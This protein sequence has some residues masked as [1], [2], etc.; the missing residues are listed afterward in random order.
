MRFTSIL[1]L[2]VKKSSSRFLHDML[3]LMCFCIAPAF[4]QYVPGVNNNVTLLGRQDKYNGYSN[5]WGYT[6]ARG[7]EYALVG[8]DVGLSVVNITNPGN[9]IEVDFVPGPGPTAW[10]EIKTF[11]HYAYVVSEASSPNQYSGVQVV[12]L[13]TLPDS[14]KSFRSYLWPN[15]TATNARAHSISVDEAGYLYIQG[16]NTT[17]GTG[18]AGNGVRILSLANPNAPA[19]VSVFNARY[20]HDSYTHKNLLFNSNIQNGGRVD[21]V[22][23]TDRANP[24]FVTAITYPNGASHNSGTTAD[25]NYLITTDEDADLTVKIWDIRVLWDNDPN[26]NGNIE[27]VAEIP[28]PAGSIAHNVH[29]RGDYAF[30]AHYTE[31][32]KVFDVSDPR[33]P[34]EVGYYDS[35]RQAGTGF[36]GDWGV[37]PYY[38]SGNFVISDM[39]TGLYVLRLDHAGV[40]EVRGR[41][42]NRET[43]AALAGATVQFVEANRILSTDNNGEYFARTNTGTHTMIVKAFPFKTD[44]VK[45]ELTSGAPVQQDRALAPVLAM[46]ALRG[47]VRDASGKAVRAK[48]SLFASSNATAPFTLTDSSDANGE[49]SFENIFVTSPPLLQYDKL[50]IE[51]A[52]P[53]VAQTEEV[54]TVVKDAP[55]VHNFALSPAQVLLVNDDPNSRYADYYLDALKNLNVTAYPWSRVQRGAV[56]VSA[57]SQFTSNV[58]IWFTGDAVGEEVLPPAERDS[59]SAHLDRGGKILLTGQNIVE[60]VQGTAFQR[61]RLH[62]AF[63]Q[64]TSDFQLHGAPGDPIGG[65][66]GTIINAGGAAANNQNSRD[67]LLPEAPAKACFVYELSSL[68][69]AG[70]RVE[71]EGNHS[72]LALLGFGLEAVVNRAGFVSRENILQN[73]LNWLNGSSA[74]AEPP[75]ANE[76]PRTFHLSASYPNPFRAA[77]RESVVRYDLPGQLAAQRVTLKIYDNLGRE[78]AIL[79]DKAYIPGAFTAAWNGRTSRGELVKSGVYFYKLHAGEMQQVR[80]VVVVR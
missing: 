36:A 17:T 43:G 62:A 52:L 71:N 45:F 28:V 7:N 16:G 59:V 70:V 40:S 53:F 30:V 78:V 4:A 72:R 8:A 65:G 32:V 1:P 74:V 34:A 64:N 54:I 3:A 79:V 11:S 50:V 55:S 56:P 61:E 49:Y 41:I 44:T 76:L 12:D 67:V 47:T 19:P 35:F 31:G 23:V 37:F 75:A 5:I 69:P 27:L 63:V 22:D 73:V 20:V 68:L 80:K 66:L 42:T 29:V 58:I 33:K 57:M 39:Q 6:D 13:S 77:A 60:S 25:G 26:N 46:S 48:V 24:K 9:P 2:P 14:V 38:P 21:V 51:P 15:V 18:G 10:R